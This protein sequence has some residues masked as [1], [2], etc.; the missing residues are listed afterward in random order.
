[1]AKPYVIELL[2]QEREELDALVRRG[3]AAARK[4]TRARALL[5]SDAGEDGPG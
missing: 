5:L 3:K 2:A 4:L 1:M